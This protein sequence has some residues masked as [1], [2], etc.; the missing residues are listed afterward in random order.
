MALDYVHL[1]SGFC[2][3]SYGSNRVLTRLH[4]PRVFGGIEGEVTLDKGRDLVGGYMGALT[5]EGTW[6]GAN[7]KA[8]WEAGRL[9]T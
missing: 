7:G 6:C 5:T 8:M 4:Q 9:Y 3:T 2:P 1:A